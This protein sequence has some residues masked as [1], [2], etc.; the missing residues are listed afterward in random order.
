LRIVKKNVKITLQHNGLIYNFDFLKV[1]LNFLF[2]IFE[3]DLGVFYCSIIY[4]KMTTNYYNKNENKTKTKYICDKCNFN[5][6]K[7]TDFNRHINTVK[8]LKL[9]NTTEIV[10][11]NDKIY[12]CNCGKVY[13][14]HSSLYNHKKT[15]NV[16]SNINNNINKE[17]ILLE[18]NNEKDNIDYKTMFLELINENQEL[19]KTITEMLPKIGNNNNNTK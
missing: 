8:H 12:K 6:C 16:N 18:T 19:R 11:K 4:Y 14:H 9:H 3:K 1:L 10:E 15:C 17:N 7:K 13:K 5:T 2:F